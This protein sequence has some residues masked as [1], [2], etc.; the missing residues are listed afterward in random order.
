MGRVGGGGGGVVQAQLTEKNSDN[1]FLGFL[2]FLQ[3]YRGVQ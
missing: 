1:V 3:F 2:S